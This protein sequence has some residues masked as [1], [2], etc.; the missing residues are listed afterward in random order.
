MSF[1]DFSFDFSQLK[2]FLN[3]L[4]KMEE[5]L[6]AHLRSETVRKD[7]EEILLSE[8]RAAVDEVGLRT[9]TG[10]LKRSFQMVGTENSGG[11]VIYNLVNTARYA[12]FLNSGTAPSAGRYVPALGRRL[13]DGGMSRGN[14]P[15]RFLD[16]IESRAAKS[17]SGSLKES[18]TSW[19]SKFLSG[20]G[21]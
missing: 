20:F 17:V 12:S 13:S 16:K 21:G 19:L 6:K 3:K 10:H 9:R 4:T 1:I 11:Q 7:M 5:S 8:A 15:Y 18:C 14:R 2:A